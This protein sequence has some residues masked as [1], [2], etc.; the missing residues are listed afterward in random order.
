[1]LDAIEALSVQIRDVERWEEGLART[2]YLRSVLTLVSGVGTVTALPYI[3]T[4][5]LPDRSWASRSNE[6]R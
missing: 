3:L 6:G 5:E 4:Q 1:M 2:E